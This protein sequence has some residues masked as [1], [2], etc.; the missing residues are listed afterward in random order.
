MSTSVA[1]PGM[2]KTKVFWNDVYDVIISAY[3]LTNKTLSPESY[4]NVDAFMWRNS[5]REVI[6]TWILWEFEQIKPFLLWSDLD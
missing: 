2:L 4:Y 1:P 5:M 6:T 3:E